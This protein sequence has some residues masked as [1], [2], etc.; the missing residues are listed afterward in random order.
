[1]VRAFDTR[2]KGILTDMHSSQT[3]YHKKFKTYSADR[4]AIG[5]VEYADLAR[6]FFTPNELPAN[7]MTVLPQQHLPYVAQDSF[8][9]LLAI[10]HKS[11]GQLDFWT[12]SHVQRIQK[13]KEKITRQYLSYKHQ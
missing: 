12:L 6:M 2:A 5:Y 13:L 4:K 10:E 8:K 3:A 1:M 7:M 11:S 9:I